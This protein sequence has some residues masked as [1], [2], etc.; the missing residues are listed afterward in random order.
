MLEYRNPGRKTFR[1]QCC[2][3]RTLDTRT[4]NC[5]TDD[6]CDPRFAISLINFD[7]A[8]M[9][10]LGTNY[11]LGTF[12]NADSISFDGCST[13]ES[14]R[15]SAGVQNPLKFVFPSTQ[16]TPGVSM[17]GNNNG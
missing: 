15:A 14:D 7:I 9:P 3:I 17:R 6:T 2:E 8:A 13:I 5:I 11:V 1:D 12:M 16:F 10:M 4:G